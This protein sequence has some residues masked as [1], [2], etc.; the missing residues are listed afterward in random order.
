MCRARERAFAQNV[1]L[2][3]VF[4][5]VCA[6]TNMWCLYAFS[7]PRTRVEYFK[8]Q[9]ANTECSCSVCIGPHATGSRA[10]IW[11]LCGSSQTAQTLHHHHHHHVVSDIVHCA[12]WFVRAAVFATQSS[13]YAISGRL[14]N[15]KI[16][17]I[18]VVSVIARRP[19]RVSSTTTPASA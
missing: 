13:A 9:Y 4:A 6:Y 18:I 19:G 3:V 5:F 8:Q 2:R 16:V 1:A 11:W 14:F 7:S 12:R 15:N 17:I 10:T